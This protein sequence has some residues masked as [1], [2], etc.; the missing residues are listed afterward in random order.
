MMIVSKLQAYGIASSSHRFNSHHDDKYDG[1]EILPSEP[2]FRRLIYI[3]NVLS[4]Y[5]P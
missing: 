3:H 5:S 2:L 1:D 4:T